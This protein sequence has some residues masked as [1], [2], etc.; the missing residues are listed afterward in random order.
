MISTRQKFS[1][2]LAMIFLAKMTR[3]VQEHLIKLPHCSGWCLN[4]LVINRMVFS[5]LPT[6]RMSAH[7][8]TSPITSGNRIRKYYE[9]VSSRILSTRKRKKGGWSIWKIYF[10]GA[11]ELKRSSSKLALIWC[12][13]KETVGLVP[14]SFYSTSNSSSPP[15]PGWFIGSQ[16]WR[17]E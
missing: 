12:R 16:Q 1:I 4:V 8:I 17:G 2:S 15:A 14:I 7:N 3:I 10:S 6:R 13:P 9:Y 5:P 11:F